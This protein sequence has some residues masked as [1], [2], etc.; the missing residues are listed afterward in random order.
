MAISLFKDTQPGLRAE[1]QKV[2]QALARLENTIGQAK[3]R[4]IETAYA[5]IYPFVAGIAFHSRLVAFW[6]DRAEE[7]RQALDFLL[8]ATQTRRLAVESRTRW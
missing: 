2:E 4:G 6:Q 3:A 7:Q 8:E 1:R 5:E